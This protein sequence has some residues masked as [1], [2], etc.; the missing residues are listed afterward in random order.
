MYI[1][2]FGQV[3]KYFTGFYQGKEILLVVKFELSQFQNWRVLLWWFYGVHGSCWFCCLLYYRSY[4]IGVILRELYFRKYIIG[5]I[6]QELYYRGYI[7]GL[8]LQDLYYRSYIIDVILQDLYYRSYIVEVILQELYYRSYIIEV[9]L[10]DLYY[11]SYIIRVVLLELG[12]IEAITKTA[13]AVKNN[14][15][16]SVIALKQTESQYQVPAPLFQFCVYSLK[17]KENLIKS[18][19]YKVISTFFLSKNQYFFSIS[20]N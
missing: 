11:R 20:L 3:K 13:S 9:I 19:L 15:C 5:L 1:L 7:I 4:T 6:L 14:N 17:F 18:F 10:Q 8:I 2:L 12:Y 16:Q